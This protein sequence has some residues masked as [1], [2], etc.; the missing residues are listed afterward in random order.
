GVEGQQARCRHECD[1]AAVSTDGTRRAVRWRLGP[2]LSQ[3]NPAW[4]SLAVRAANQHDNRQHHTQAEH[5]DLRSR[6][7]CTSA[8]TSLPTT[9]A[10]RVS[11]TGGVPFA[12]APWT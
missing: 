6:Y 8:A 11:K 5:H 12:L 4:L 2:S 10:R 9:T 7:A 1:I 3:H